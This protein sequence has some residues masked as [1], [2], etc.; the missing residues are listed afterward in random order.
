MSRGGSRGFTL[1]EVLAATALTAVLM[2]AVLQVLGT[3]SRSRSAMEK[4]AEGAAPWREDLVDTVRRDLN[5]ATGVRFAPNGIVLAS[6]AALR[7]SSLAATDEPVTV[8]Y[9]LTEIHGRNWL[10]RRQAVRAGFDGGGA[11]WTELLCPDVAAFEMTPAAA[12]LVQAG[13]A[14]GAKSDLQPVPAAASMRV[15]LTDGSVI[16]QVLVLR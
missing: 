1:V 6:H 4:R 7:P 8:T 13:S 9:G 10:C 12:G 5:S 3:L 11:P 14:A 16:E 15:T 2:L